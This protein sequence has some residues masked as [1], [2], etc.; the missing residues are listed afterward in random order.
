MVCAATGHDFASWNG[1]PAALA[2]PPSVVLASISPPAICLWSTRA[3]RCL[4]PCVSTAAARS[5]C[6]SSG[7]TPRGRMGRARPGDRPAASQYPSRT[8]RDPLRPRW[9]AP[10]RSRASR[11]RS[12]ALA[13]VGHSGDP[14]RTLL[15]DGE[16]I[17]YSYVPLPVPL[18]H[19][20]TVYAGLPVRSRH[21]RLAVISRGN[22]SA[23]C[24][25]MGWT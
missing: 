11:R 20:Q 7:G 21:P 19:Y 25:G 3:A 22:C 13:Y 18:E 1:Q 12:A 15:S 8:G 4:L 17:R 5:R 16:P 24:V 6:N 23:S 2:T 9:P 10:S 14:V